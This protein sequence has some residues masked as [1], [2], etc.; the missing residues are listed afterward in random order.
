MNS[1]YSVC[2]M[3]IDC[4]LPGW[5]SRL[6]GPTVTSIWAQLSQVLKLRNWGLSP[7]KMNSH[8]SDWIANLTESIK[9]NSVSK[10]IYGNIKI[11]MSRLKDFKKGLSSDWD[12][13]YRHVCGRIHSLANWGIGDA[14][15]KN[16][17][18]PFL[19]AQTSLT[20][21]PM[22]WSVSRSFLV[23]WMV[24]SKKLTIVH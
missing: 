19:D 5:L 24:N 13:F 6:S 1:T 14:L 8:H 7:M 20:P 12:S 15:Q 11:I 9:E 3:C 4:R 10:Q 16:L 21:T 17:S 18:L 22:I 2:S 23:S